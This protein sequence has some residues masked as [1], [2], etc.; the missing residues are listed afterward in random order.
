MI[1]IPL[2]PPV[3]EKAPVA[4]KEEIRARVPEGKLQEEAKGRT[5]RASSSETVGSVR[6]EEAANGAM[7]L[8]LSKQ[9]VR[10]NIRSIT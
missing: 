8:R 1:P 10:S 5:D 9:L 3:K 2:D 6:E 7:T 4:R